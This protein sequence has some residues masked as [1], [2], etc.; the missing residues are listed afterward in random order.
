[1]IKIDFDDYC[2]MYR[3]MFL[4]KKYKHIIIIKELFLMKLKKAKGE[5]I[6]NGFVSSSKPAKL[7]YII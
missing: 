1:M 5:N 3:Q 6:S 2:C 4:N 7:Y